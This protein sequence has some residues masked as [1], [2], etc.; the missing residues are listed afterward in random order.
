MASACVGGM[1][2]TKEHWI[3]RLARDNG[4]HRKLACGNR[5]QHASGTT[6]RALVTCARCALWMA[7]HPLLVAAVSGRKVV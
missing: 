5:N 2:G 1:T 7:R 3:V 4:G 6:D